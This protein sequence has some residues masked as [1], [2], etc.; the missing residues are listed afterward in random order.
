M[1]NKLKK[2]DLTSL[3]PNLVEVLDAYGKTLVEKYRQGLTDG[4]HIATGN[5]Y[6]SVSSEVT[7]NGQSF[8]VEFRMPE[9][10]EYLEQG[11]KPHF[12][13]WSD[14]NEGIWAWVRAKR[15][16]YRRDDQGRLPTEKQLS[17]LIA[18]KISEEGTPA[19]HLWEKANALTFN[20]WNKLIDEAINMD[21]NENLEE[22]LQTLN[23]KTKVRSRKKR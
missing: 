7:L 17:Y 15:I 1:A 22:I 3:F 16:A 20:E 8:I 23:Q 6:R 19:T 13:P 21:L 18:R 9:Y 4:D 10:G 14:P 2:N 5:L 12:P 11:T